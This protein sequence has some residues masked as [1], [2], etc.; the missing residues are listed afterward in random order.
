MSP[1]G[2]K[3]RIDGILSDQSWE[4]EITRLEDFWF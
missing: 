1:V 4:M 3:S 2:P